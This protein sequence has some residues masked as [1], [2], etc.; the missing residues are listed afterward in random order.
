MYKQGSFPNFKE[1]QMKNTIKTLVENNVNAR[2][3][4]GKLS[5]VIGIT[6]IVVLVVMCNMDINYVITGTTIAS[7]AVLVQLATGVYDRGAIV[8]MPFLFA[9]YVTIYMAIAYIC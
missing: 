2:A 7:M 8:C 5:T 1:K 9:L 4:L 3:K 6:I